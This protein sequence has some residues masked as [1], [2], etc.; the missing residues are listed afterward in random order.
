MSRVQRAEHAQAFC[1]EV[2]EMLGE[3]LARQLL[4][5]IAYNDLQ[6]K[7]TKIELD[8]DATQKE[9]ILDRFSQHFV[10][11]EVSRFFCCLVGKNRICLLPRSYEE[12][13]L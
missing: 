4:W 5:K 9:A 10:G 3:K 2:M 7:I 11:R 13:I 8:V 12:L 6:V 1:D